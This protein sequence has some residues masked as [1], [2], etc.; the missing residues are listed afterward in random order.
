MLIKPV[1]IPN[2]KGLLT[3]GA[4]PELAVLRPNTNDVIPAFTFFNEA[5]NRDTSRRS[6]TDAPIGTDGNPDTL[7]LRPHYANDP[8]TLANTI[9]GLLVQ[10]V[11]EYP[12]MGRCNIVP[13]CNSLSVG[14]HIHFGSVEN[15]DKQIYYLDHGLS[16]PLSFLENPGHRRRRKIQGNYG[17][18]S[19][20]RGQTWGW[21][22]RTPPSWLG[23]QKL[24]AGT[25]SL[26]YALAYE[27]IF[28]DK[29][30]F[31]F[32]PYED[33]AIIE[34][35]NHDQQ[36]MLGFVLDRVITDV[37]RLELY[38]P[39][40]QHINYII[41]SSRAGRPLVDSEVKQGWHILRFLRK[42]K[43]LREFKVLL[44]HITR[45]IE[46]QVRGTNSNFVRIF[47][48]EEGMIRTNSISLTCNLVLKRVLGDQLNEMGY[49]NDFGV[50]GGPTGGPIQIMGW[51]YIP[52]M[53]QK[54]M[55]ALSATL[56]T[57]IKEFTG[58]DRNIELFIGRGKAIRL[59]RDIRKNT[60]YLAE[61][62]VLLT[63][64]YTTRTAYKAEKRTGERMTTI[65][66]RR[67]EIIPILARLKNKNADINMEGRDRP[68]GED[69]SF[70]SF[71]YESAMREV[72]TMGD[73]NV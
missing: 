29:N 48:P 11:K 42:T 14:G 41:N 1:S 22:Y 19:D 38:K 39:Y 9:Q 53:T 37:K 31:K 15:R 2:P 16:L 55:R 73:Q 20:A 47:T 71:S 60:H 44:K 46:S 70:T 69:I 68:N 62:I 52:G 61:L 40:R 8:L 67:A 34:A 72:N 24:T 59:P 57:L 7:E 63:W 50:Q 10:L 30:L 23:N 64:L 43:K 4:D 17:R 5:M 49:L 35:F 25:L 12:S 26:A 13:S 58:E 28:N 21:E 36:A 6:F 33:K 54:R 56:Q 3:I 65:P 51:G 32:Q 66:I 45:V 27:A 18:L